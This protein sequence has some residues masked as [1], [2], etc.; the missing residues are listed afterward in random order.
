MSNSPEGI[1]PPSGLEKVYRAVQIQLPAEYFD[2]FNAAFHRAL[3]S[4]QTYHAIEQSVRAALRERLQEHPAAAGVD[5]ES[6]K[7]VDLI[8]LLWSECVQQNADPTDHTAA[9]T[10]FTDFFVTT[11]TEHA[12]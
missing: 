2:T 12:E 4:G 6:D 7:L 5:F 3:V 8:G 10:V 9:A 11:L 1:S